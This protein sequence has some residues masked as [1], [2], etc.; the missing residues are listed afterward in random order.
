MKL[1][2]KNLLKY[3][4]ELFYF[5]SISLFLFFI[6]EIIWPNFVLTYFNINFLLFIWLLNIF[7][8]LF[9]KRN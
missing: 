6:L 5:L 1:Y 4:Q 8:L 2:K 3:S 7:Y 9:N